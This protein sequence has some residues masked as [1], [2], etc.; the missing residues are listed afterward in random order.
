[1][2]AADVGDTVGWVVDGE[3]SQSLCS[4][5]CGSSPK[6]PAKDRFWELV[7]FIHPRGLGPPV[8]PNLSP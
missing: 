4:G 8:D 6:L 1:M 3:G 7:S 2:T 5:A